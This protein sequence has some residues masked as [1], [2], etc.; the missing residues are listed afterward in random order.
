MIDRLERS[1]SR[2]VAAKRKKGE[3]GSSPVL[4]NLIFGRIP[5][6]RSVRDGFFS[7][8]LSPLGRKQADEGTAEGDSA[9]INEADW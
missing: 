5:D 4:G 2:A 3:I 1:L 9:K 8:L 7:F 6:W